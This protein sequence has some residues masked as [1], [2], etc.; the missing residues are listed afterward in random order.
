MVVVVVG[1]VVGGGGGGSRC[2][3]QFIIFLS[4]F[5]L[6]QLFREQLSILEMPPI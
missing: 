6:V 1:G 4:E 5:I 3:V 2:A